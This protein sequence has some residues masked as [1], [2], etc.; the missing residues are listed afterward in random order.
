[1]CGI[2]ALIEENEATNYDQY[3]KLVKSVSELLHHRGP[4][5]SGHKLI[6]DPQT[7]KN[8]LLQH[9]RL[10]INGDSTPQPLYDANKTMYLIINGEIFNWKQLE[11]ELG[12]QCQ[13]SDCEIILPLYKKYSHDIRL[14]LQKLNGQFSFVL[15]DLTTKHILIARDQI[16][17]TPLYIGFSDHNSKRIAIAS[18]LKCLINLTSNIR[19]FKP[20]Q[21]I[22]TNLD[23][24]SLSSE[25]NDFKNFYGADYLSTSLKTEIKLVPREQHLEQIKD[26]LSTSVKLQLQDLLSNRVEFGVLLSGG[27]DSS[28]ISSLVVKLAREMGYGE[29]IKTFS[30][31][32]NSE[33]PDLVAARKVATYLH[34]NHHEYYFDVKEAL[35]TVP[36]IIWSIESYDCT[37]V[38]A[39]TP[40][41]LLTRQIKANFPQ[42]RVVFSGELSDELL[43]YLY[44]ANA[45]NEVEFQQ[46]TVNLVSSVHM[47][48]CLR[49]NKCCMAHSL[50]VRV[51]FSDPNYVDYILKLHPQYKMFGKNTGQ[52]EKQI[53]RDSFIGYLPSEILYRKKEQFSDGV[54]GFKKTENWIDSI[55]QFVE[56][57][58]SEEQYEIQRQNYTYNRPDTKEKL[59]YRQLFCKWFNH[60]SY[61][62]TS[63]F[64]VREWKP[65]W[66]ADLD[67][68]GRRQTFWDK[69]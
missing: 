44:G 17:V 68:S 48:D 38:R 13:M 18:E 58:F 36:N 56:T 59:W 23:D 52:M 42:M 46:E 20:R 69:N 55:K 34:T 64:T 35:S 62:N 16:G 1:M 65:K 5:A 32:L 51:P 50:E 30:I 24:F 67:P 12:Y 47:F 26:L 3:S 4:D 14:M 19:S 43:C 2:F 25:V 8:I 57:M 9:A 63:E 31:G 7:N 6:V 21:Y 27:L 61:G 11:Q 28:L 53:L 40:M 15:F 33:V 66:C 29:P 37:T 10:H 49:A 54:S 22:Y 41:Y 45:P 39:S 60:K